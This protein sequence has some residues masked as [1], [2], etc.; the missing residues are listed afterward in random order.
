MIWLDKFLFLSIGLG[1]ILYFMLGKINEMGIPMDRGMMII[2]VI[3][4]SLVTL[5]CV[6]YLRSEDQKT[7]QK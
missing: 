3:I 4:M 1:S 5:S 6:L 7:K 2:L